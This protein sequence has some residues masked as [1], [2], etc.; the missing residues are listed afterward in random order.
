[1]D[2]RVLAAALLALV[3]GA[4]A[5]GLVTARLAPPGEA[6]VEP[7]GTGGG[8]AALIGVPDATP[9]RVYEGGFDFTASPLPTSRLDAFVVRAGDTA[10]HVSA[11]WTE[12]AVPTVRSSTLV[13]LRGPDGY[14]YWRCSTGSCGVRIDEP[15]PGLWKLLYDGSQGRVDV[16]AQ[17]VRG[18]DLPP[19]REELFNGSLFWQTSLH[20]PSNE[21]GFVVEADGTPLRLRIEQPG[22]AGG[23]T[24]SFVVRLLDPDGTEI[25]QCTESCEFEGRGEAGRWTLAF[26][27]PP[28][29]SAR[30]FVERRAP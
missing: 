15:A 30:A 28:L 20:N 18:P 1:M 21:A 14:E 2:P 5:G 27:G 19:A 26:T 10:L 24:G 22:L 8:L 3:L 11:N 12:M 7:A 17:L 29:T 9:R 25:L 13:S 23:R 16:E 4:G 6:P